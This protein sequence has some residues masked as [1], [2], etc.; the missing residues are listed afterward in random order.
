MM[1]SHKAT[2]RKAAKNT[3]CLVEKNLKQSILAMDPNAEENTKT[4]IPSRIHRRL[5]YQGMFGFANCQRASHK[6]TVQLKH[7][8]LIVDMLSLMWELSTCQKIE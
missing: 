4:H 2:I 6:F 8:L 7:S 1:I 5:S 3:F